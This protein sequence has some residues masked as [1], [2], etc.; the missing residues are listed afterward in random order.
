MSFPVTEHS[1]KREHAVI[2]V[3]DNHTPSI[4]SKS[5]FKIIENYI[6][7]TINRCIPTAYFPTLYP[8]SP[9]SFTIP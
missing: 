4:S 3:E 2:L 5:F 9:S 1:T 8:T 7:L 6:C